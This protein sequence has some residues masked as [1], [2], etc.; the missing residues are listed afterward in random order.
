MVRDAGGDDNQGAVVLELAVVRHDAAVAGLR[1]ADVVGLPVGA[2][3]GVDQVDGCLL[4]FLQLIGR[5]WTLAY[6]IICLSLYVIVAERSSDEANEED[7]IEERHGGLR[8]C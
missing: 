2:G 6:L 7:S 3:S 4:V 5:L 1:G 8:N